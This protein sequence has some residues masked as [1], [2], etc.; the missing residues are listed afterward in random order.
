MCIAR[1]TIV[2]AFCTNV[3]RIQGLIMMPMAC[4]IPICQIADYL[5]FAFGIRTG[6]M[7]PPES[8]ASNPVASCLHP[9]L[10]SYVFC[11]TGLSKSQHVAM[12]GDQLH[13]RVNTAAVEV[14]TF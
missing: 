14:C 9:I 4:D 12:P 5:C 1:V 10:L 7:V 2:T 3:L 13:A 6:G 11:I 8:I